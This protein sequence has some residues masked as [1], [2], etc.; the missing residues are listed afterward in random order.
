MK[1]YYAILK[2]SGG[3]YSYRKLL[4]KSREEALRSLGT[5]KEIRFL[6]TWKA[7]SRQ[8]NRNLVLDFS[9]DFLFLIS[10]GLSYLE[11]LEAMSHYEKKSI[12]RYVLA[13][14]SK[15][16]H[17][18]LGLHAS[19]SGLS[20]FFDAFY[21]N[22]LYIGERSGNVEKSLEM[23]IAHMEEEKKLKK[24][25]ISLLSYPI[26]LVLFSQFVV[27]ILLYSVLP[28]FLE[29]FDEVGA[30][31]PFLTR[32]LL[33][34]KQVFPCFL[35]FLFLLFLAFRYIYQRKYPSHWQEKMDS[36]LFWHF[37][38]RKFY[39]RLLSYRLMKSFELLLSSGFGIQEILP[40]L[41]GGFV[42]LA[43]KEQFQKMQRD[44]YR[45]KNLTK[46]FQN[47]VV[48][49]E[50]EQYM[51]SLGEKGGNLVDIFSLMAIQIQLEIQER[52]QYY[53][54]ILEPALLLFLGAIIG[55]VILG[56]Y[57]PIFSMANLF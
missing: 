44:L 43:L 15:S 17:Q 14:I 1:Y 5:R 49:G 6:W 35:L 36:F 53:F 26:F 3:G 54:R 48:L 37:Q 29:I 20:S 23:L 33:A 21:L 9:K 55:M 31:L 50:K 40:I 56:L 30:E 11:S 19:F 16:L 57:L 52:I 51:I 45:G 39:S 13:E 27:G 41:E 22:M 24:Q 34:L 18:G 28:Q 10:N 2:K 4:A 25:M 8:E 42:N 46:A 7:L 32:C 12:Q 47:L 38:Y